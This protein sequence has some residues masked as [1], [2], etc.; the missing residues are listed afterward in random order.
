MKQNVLEVHSHQQ[1]NEDE[2]IGLYLHGLV[3][4]TGR[5]QAFILALVVVT[6]LAGILLVGVGLYLG[7]FWGI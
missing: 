4:D 1:E 5:E 6:V 2:E 7:I 3:Q